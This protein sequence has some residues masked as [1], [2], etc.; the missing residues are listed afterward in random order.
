MRYLTEFRDPSRIEHAAARL[1]AVTTRAWAIMEICGGQ[2]H[3][4]VRH[5]LE[6]LLP[7][8]MVLIHGPGCPVCVT[9]VAVL[10][11]A[12]TLAVGHGAIL[13]SF[14]DMLR[15]PGQHGDLLAARAEG[16][17]IRVVLS[18]LDALDVARAAP[19]REVV[20]FGVGFE[21]TAPA[22]A[23]A[24]ELAQRTGLRNFSVLAAHVRVPP[25]IEQILADPDHRIHGLLAAGHVCTV[26]GTAAYAPLAHR[27][28]VPI[29]VTGFEPVDILLGLVAVVED[30]EAGRATVRNAYRRAVRDAGN[31]LAQQ[32][33]DRIFEVVDAPWRGLGIVPKG[34]L[35]IREGF[36]QYD[37]PRRFPLPLATIPETTACQAASVLRGLM[38]PCECPEFGKACTPEHPLGA[39]MVSSEGACAAYHRYDPASRDDRG[40]T[41]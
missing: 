23:M 39:P 28:G 16:G 34:G 25:A 2:T 19:D 11:A 13:C 38:R 6:Q 9:P 3:S 26:E 10:E 20:F 18:P 30:L 33:V 8:G 31:E 29:A 7:P 24:I 27:F 15:V 4:I 14:G 37:A 35:R 40:A 1:R 22:A 12:R 41:P 21:T 32:A 36:A 17:D 5:G